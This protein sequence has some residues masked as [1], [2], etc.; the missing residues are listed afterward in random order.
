MSSSGTP[1]MSTNGSDVSDGNDDPRPPPQ[2][3]AGDV[4]QPGPSVAQ[5]ANTILQQL[6]I[7]LLLER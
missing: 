2:P 5:Q 4:L 3:L 6:M 1:I 7:E